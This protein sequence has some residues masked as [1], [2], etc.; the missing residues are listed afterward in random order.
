MPELLNKLQIFPISNWY[1][2]LSLASELGF[3]DFELLYD[4]EKVFLEIIS[5]QENHNILCLD[6][7]VNNKV[8]RPKSICLDFISSMSLINKTKIEK[9]IDELRKAILLFRN[10]K[11]QM[12]VVPFCDDSVVPDL[13]TLKEALQTIDDSNLDSLAADCGLQLAL[14]LTLPGHMLVEGFSKH[15]F[16]NIG[17]CFDLG[18][19]R[20]SGLQ[21]ES[22]IL[23]LG[24]L[25]RH[26]HIKDRSVGGSNV[27]LGHGDVDFE[28]C[29]KSLKKINYTGICI[30]E[31]RYF[32][33]PIK[34]AS[35]NLDYLKGLVV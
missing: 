5:V 15:S 27:M 24:S 26:V 23:D 14:E 6:L 32:T 1:A 7:D 19:I 31:T 22:G 20:S 16:T 17:I 25:V 4:K 12:L 29:F 34:E 28:A 9:F 35:T 2:E 10:S 21:P 3:D 33:D 30:M 13:A 11:I 18:N 8:I